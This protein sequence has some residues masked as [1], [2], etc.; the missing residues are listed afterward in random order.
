VKSQGR[1]YAP[2]NTQGFELG[3]QFFEYLSFE[4]EYFANTQN[5]YIFYLQ[6]LANFEK[7][8]LK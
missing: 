3:F 5:T 8:N 2:E 7:D 6:S 1:T 4:F